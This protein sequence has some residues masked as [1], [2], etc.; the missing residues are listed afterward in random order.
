MKRNDIATIILVAGVAAII[1]FLI[2]GSIFGT[3]NRSTQVP[4][5]SSIPKDFPDVKNDSSYNAFLNDKALDP[6]L[7]IQIGGSSNSNPF[8]H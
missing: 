5:V 8:N 7:P 3:K 4:V 1:S 2:A 6:T